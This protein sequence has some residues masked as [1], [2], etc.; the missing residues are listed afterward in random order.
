MVFNGRV[1]LNHEAH[2]FRESNDDSLVVLNIIAGKSCNPK[3][4]TKL[5][6]SVLSSEFQKL[7]GGEHF[8]L[9]VLIVY[10]QGIGEFGRTTGF[11]AANSG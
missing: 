6:V 1:N 3:T 5:L 9:E 4:K 7:Q 8:L 2:G 11:A 10:V